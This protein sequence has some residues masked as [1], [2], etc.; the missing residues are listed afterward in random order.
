MISHFAEAG[1]CFYWRALLGARQP[2]AVFKNGIEVV[3]IVPCEC[4]RMAA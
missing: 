4:L 3:Q 2:C 1:S